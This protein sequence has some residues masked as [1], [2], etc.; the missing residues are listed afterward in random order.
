[1]EILINTAAPLT[2]FYSDFSGVGVT[3]LT[4]T[5][6]IYNPSNVQVVTAG[7]CTERGGG[8]YDYSYTPTVAGF[9]RVLFKTAVTTVSAQQLSLGFECVSY[10]ASTLTTA[11]AGIDVDLT[12]VTDALAVVDANVDTLLV[13][14]AAVDGKADDIIEDIYDL[15]HDGSTPIVRV[16]PPPETPNT[17]RVYEYAYTQS[18]AE[19]L[20]PV[21]ATAKITDLPFDY[22]GVLHDGSVIE[23]SETSPDGDGNYVIYWDLPYTAE[24]VIIL[25]EHGVRH[26]ITVPEE[27]SAR[28]ADLI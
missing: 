14:V 1:M 28:V 10:N 6:D 25:T 24:V 18:G 16:I 2:V 15:T 3:G 17:C 11:I 26:Q 23:A 12:P 8:F 7:A 27:E 19:P 13:D 21:H 5:I 4:V 20:D 9:F 22:N